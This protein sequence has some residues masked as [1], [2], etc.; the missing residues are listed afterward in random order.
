MDL[1]QI[2]VNPSFVDLFGDCFQSTQSSHT[3][4]IKP[5]IQEYLKQLEMV[6]ITVREQLIQDMYLTQPPCKVLR[7]YALRR[8]SDGLR[9]VGQVHQTN[10]V[11]IGDLL[12]ML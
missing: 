2:K 12:Y 9:V 8:I 4:T 5:H 6:K 7:I 11:C 3:I 10:G 1:S